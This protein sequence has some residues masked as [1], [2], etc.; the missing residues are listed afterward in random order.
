MTSRREAEIDAL[1][2]FAAQFGEDRARDVE[3]VTTSSDD[4]WIVSFRPKDGSTMD[5]GIRVVV[6]EETGECFVYPTSAPVRGTIAR[7]LR[8]KSDSQLRSDKGDSS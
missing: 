1:T 7:H 2:M 6:E 5:G 4:L 3:P 8:S